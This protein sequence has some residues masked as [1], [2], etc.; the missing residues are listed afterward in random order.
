MPFVAWGRRMALSDHVAERGAVS[1]PSGQVS[2]GRPRVAE[3][4]SFL[5]PRPGNDNQR[6]PSDDWPAYELDCLRGVLSPELLRQA[7]AR[8]RKLGIG[9]DQVLIQQG[10]IAEAAY[11]RHLSGHTGIAIDDL[12]EI[13]RGGL[14][15][16][17][18]QISLAA[19]RG[20]AHVRKNGR[21]LV[22]TAPR[23]LAVRRLC[24]A[25]AADPSLKTDMRLTSHSALQQFLLQ[26]CASALARGATR[27]LSDKHP[28]LSAAPAAA[29]DRLWRGR[30]KRGC[31]VATVVLLPPFVVFDLWSGALA[32]WF[33]GFVALRMAG[34]FWPRRKAL[35]LLRRS[36]SRLPA[37]TIIVA[38]YHEA[39]SVAPLL[40][41]IDALD[42]PR[43]KLDVILVVEPDD[44][45]TH[46]AIARLR[47]QV[48]ARTVV[49]PA[50][51]P[52]TKPKA[53]NCALPFVRG[54][55]VAVYDA[56]DRPE[57]R[58]LRA[59]LD[60]FR[61]HD[62]TIACAQAS[63]CIDNA[64]HSWLSRTFATEYAGHFDAV[65]P[66][67]SAMGL[68]LPLGGSS[69]HFRTDVL[70]K[71]GG[72]DAYNVTEDADLGFRLARFG[73]R[74]VTFASTTFEEAPIA[75]RAWL[76]QR[77][78]W[79]KGWLQTWC[80]HMR[81]PILLWRDAGPAG[82]FALNLL[83]GGNI[84]SAL[85][86]PV[87]L[88]ALFWHLAGG[89]WSWSRPDWPALLY[90]AVFLSGCGST[91]VIGLMGLAQRGRLRDGWILVM[92]PLYWGCLSRAAWRAV[93]HYVWTPY[94]WEKTEH[95]VAKRIGLRTALRR[96][97]SRERR[98]RQR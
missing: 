76:P 53:L 83:A 48:H 49:A 28:K 15:F 57:P 78:R 64:T 47:P 89:T 55:F 63:L 60:V 1:S 27:G 93:F 73:Y 33:F 95:G 54:S 13:D 18:D 61:S 97:A 67:L 12:S 82:F 35:R 17:D 21:L 80:V 51:A 79:M 62:D 58:Q 71:V 86:Y 29:T 75:F 41:A 4:P 36:E 66:G 31:A 34:A 23:Q 91:I 7:E 90:L 88:G 43:E 38:L 25:V 20:M 32:L 81:H 87:M 69:N 65:L 8:A 40:Q 84:V 52:R 50:V 14:L 56:E 19:E 94:Q 5:L 68:P 10:A 16:S 70:R 9:A 42:Y 11:L 37:Y 26:R 6:H 2:A 85:A 46:A 92:T 45:D 72:W 96:F 24:R 30:L 39:S 3:L 44:R 77:T 59:A 98:L 22:V 74:S